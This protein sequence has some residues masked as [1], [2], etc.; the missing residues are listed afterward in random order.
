MLVPWPNEIFK[1]F[2]APVTWALVALNYMVFLLTHAVGTQ[3]KQDIRAIFLSEQYVQTQGHVYAEYVKMHGEKNQYSDDRKKLAVL[4]SQG[5]KTRVMSRF[6]LND[7]NFVREGRAYDYQGDQV[8]ISEWK[9]QFSTFLSLREGGP[10][11]TMGLSSIDDGWVPWLSYQFSHSGF[12]HFL[13]NMAFL[14][15]FGTLL[16]LAVGGLWVLVVYLLSG[17]LAALFFLWSAGGESMVPLVGASGSVSGLMALY[18]VRCWKQSVR[19]FYFLFVPK[20]EYLG[21]IYLPGWVLLFMWG[22]SD[23]A[24]FL[25]SMEEFG[26]VAYVAHLGGQVAGGGVGVLFGFMQRWRGLGYLNPN[27]SPIS[28]N[29]LNPPLGTHISFAEIHPDR[30]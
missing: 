6:A 25:G 9:Q 27:D 22:A 24:G 13:G 10:F 1:R 29:P 7:P 3:T 17:F 14:L 2:A 4:V 28:L 30:R 20:I 26:R 18:S 5:R 19:F 8:A 23:L 12:L 11:S 16:E 15:L 21:Y